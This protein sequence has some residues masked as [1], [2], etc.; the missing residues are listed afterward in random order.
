MYVFSFSILGEYE[1]SELL[2][3]LYFLQSEMKTNWSDITLHK[4]QAKEKFS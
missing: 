2:R 3:F 1:V 4:I